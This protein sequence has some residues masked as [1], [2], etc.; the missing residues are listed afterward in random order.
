MDDA[1]ETAITFDV[2]SGVPTSNQMVAL[3][4]AHDA[5]P[6]RRVLARLSASEAEALVNS[7]DLTM[8]SPLH[9]ACTRMRAEQVRLLLAHHANPNAAAGHTDT[10]LHKAAWGGKLEIVKL[11]VDAGAATNAVS[12]TMGE[13]PL[14]DASMNGHLAVVAYLV[15]TGAAV[16]LLNPR[17]Q[18]PLR[19]ANHFSHVDVACHLFRAGADCHRINQRTVD[20]QRPYLLQAPH[21]RSQHASAVVQ[22]HL[23]IVGGNVAEP[24][25]GVSFFQ[26]DLSHQAPRALGQTPGTVALQRPAGHTAT[27]SIVDE[28]LAAAAAADDRG[29]PVGR[30]P[31]KLFVPHEKRTANL[32][33]SG[34][35][36]E[37]TSAAD[38]GVGLTLSNA[39]LAPNVTPDI[40]YYEVTILDGGRRG[41]IAVG[42]SHPSP[43]VDKMVGWFTGS[44]AIHG[45]DGKAY[46]S[47]ATGQLFG[48]KF[49]T[50]GNVVGVG[51]NFREQEVFFTFNGEFVGVAYR[52]VASA[53]PDLPFNDL[54]AAVAL[55]S[56]GEKIEVNFGDAPFMF[57]FQATQLKWQRPLVAGDVP[58]LSAG[59]WRALSLR[60]ESAL[61][62]MV[63]SRLNR[64]F[65]LTGNPK[66]GWRL[67]AHFVKNAEEPFVARRSLCVT[68]DGTVFAL[69]TR[70]ESPAV[71][72]RLVADPSIENN[73]DFYGRWEDVE[74]ADGSPAPPRVDGASLVDVGDDLLAVIGGRTSEARRFR[75]TDEVLDD[76]VRQACLFFDLRKRQWLGV[77]QIVGCERGRVGECVEALVHVCLGHASA[78][79][80]GG[81]AVFFGGWDGKRMRGDLTLLSAR[82]ETDDRTTLR[83]DASTPHS[84]GAAT[85]M[86]RNRATIDALPDGRLLVFGGW[87]G[88]KRSGD[89]DIGTLRAVSVQT[90][91]L[92]TLTTRNF[93]DVSLVTDD[94]RSFAAHKVVLR[95]RCRGLQFA[96]DASE[97][98]VPFVK[99]TQLDLLLHFA[100][101]DL[102]PIDL[103]LT[104]AEVRSFLTD[105]VARLAPEHD[106]RLTELLVSLK[107]KTPSRFA[108]DLA[109]AYEVAP[110]DAPAPRGYDAKLLLADGRVVYAHRAL[111][112]S[113]SAFFEGAL[114]GALAKA[115]G[116][117]DVSDTDVALLLAVVDWLCTGEVR[118]GE[119]DIG[120]RVVEL[121]AVACKLG[122]SELAD[123]CDSLIVPL[124][125]ASNARWLLS[126][127]LSLGRTALAKTCR[128]ALQRV[129]GTALPSDD[130]LQA[131]FA[132]AQAQ[133]DS[134]DEGGDDDDAE[135]E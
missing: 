63:D 125:E 111:L 79:L 127:A 98:R 110:G 18:S 134:D 20:W 15:E 101:G 130:Q 112:S 115:D 53:R 108:S 74:P 96:D 99:S 8:W 133:G 116:V 62:F 26:L 37:F 85:V 55:Y 5:E 94:G 35:T 17:C 78:S 92:R 42:V 16:S 25:V 89:L 13:T 104:S 71:L 21:A 1:D 103:A 3:C 129:M 64:L 12:A 80:S 100:Y 31:P 49:S 131:E 107:L 61:L 135:E 68:A 52:A 124:V 109:H 128:D 9:W 40:A 14:F 118:F 22:G 126:F 6:L 29:P 54:F 81:G 4:T 56:L 10:P 58:L 90:R 32:T 106:A 93:A 24:D 132:L 76:A 39:P 38:V 11:L 59:T 69:F 105:C 19:I 117:V 77:D 73:L 36:V 7:S 27:D 2:T 60:G 48:P 88:A 57:E 82:F 44:V 114:V 72:R 51:V 70:V 123:V 46:V 30:K 97:V 41:F 47:A 34:T 102:L 122:C 43:P 83:V 113:S 95:R 86:P 119:N 45:D 120:A 23:V 84:S 65:H 87:T 66:S 91:L 67:Q 33:V 75:P 28:L 50:P 121:L